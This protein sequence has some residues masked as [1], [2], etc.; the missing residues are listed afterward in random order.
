MESMQTTFNNAL[1]G[2]LTFLTQSPTS[3]IIGLLLICYASYLRPS[4]PNGMSW[5][6]D[7]FVARIAILSLI[8]WTS[9]KNPTM[10]LVI[11]LAFVVTLNVANGKGAFENF[12]GPKTAILP[13]C[14]GLTMYDLLAAY[15]GDK[16]ELV[17]EMVRCKVPP[18]VKLNDEYAG[19]IATYIVNFTGKKFTAKC[20]PPY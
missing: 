4:V 7:N 11:A 14:L 19:L 6:F 17:R 10:S 15:N 1:E 18:Q 8:L 20:A 3:E 9:N 5:L 16:D 12:E 13:G 2:P